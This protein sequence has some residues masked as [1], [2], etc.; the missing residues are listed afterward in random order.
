MAVHLQKEEDRLKKRILA[1]GALVEAAVGKA[2]ASIEKGDVKLAQSVLDS[3]NEIDEKEVCLEEDCL[4]ALA[5][6][7]PVASDL[8]FVVA[9][10]KIN[11]DLERIGDLAGTIASH[12]RELIEDGGTKIAFDFGKMGERVQRMLRCSLDALV[13]RDVGL[14]AEVCRSDD[15]IDDMHKQVYRIVEESIC[16]DASRTGNF[17]QFLAI[18]RS[19]ERIADHATN[20][21]EDVIYMIGGTIIRHRPFGGRKS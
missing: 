18:S 8:R 14:A 2:V 13:N 21:A 3:D 16:R 4:K 5:L 7:Q 1:L 20:I 11:N 10:I 6:F 15:V 12:M 9:V 19:L 17:I